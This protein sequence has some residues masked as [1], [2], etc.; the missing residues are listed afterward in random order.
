MVSVRVC[1]PLGM[2]CCFRYDVELY[3]RIE[4]LIGKKLPEYPT[5]KNEVMQF[6]ERVF[7]AQRIS[8]M[9]RTA[10]VNAK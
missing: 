6:S 5:E 8:K 10:A 9:V 4:Y 7:E 2:C 1:K 3:Q